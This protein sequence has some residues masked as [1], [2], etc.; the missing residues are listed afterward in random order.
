MHLSRFLPLSLV[1]AVLSCTAAFG[2]ATQYFWDDFD[3][4]DLFDSE[5][6]YS[7]ADEAK[8]GFE[9]QEGSL[10]V[11]SLADDIPGVAVSIEDTP[12]FL[13]KTQAKLLGAQVCDI[14]PYLA[15]FG[16]W[17][18]VVGGAYWGG[19]SSNGRLTLG[20]SFA[21]V[22][23]RKIRFKYSCTEM[24]EQ[25]VHMELRAVGEQFEFTSWL[26]GTTKPT[27]P[28]L[29]MTDDTFD[30]N[31]LVGVYINPSAQLE[32]FALRY[33]AMLPAFAGD[34]N[35]TNALDAEDIDL[36]AEQITIA[37]NNR[38]YDLNEDTIVDEDDLTFL[39]HDLLNTYYGD[40]NLDGEFN[41]SDLVAVFEAGQYEDAI[42]LNSGWA[43]G[44]WNG[45]SEFTSADLVRAFQGGGYEQGPQAAIM[46][47]PEPGTLGCGVLGLIGLLSLAR[48]N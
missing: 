1:A 15:L 2:Q 44:D 36:L 6:A 27:E 7:P 42:A 32:G 29:V 20:E 9:L 5:I 47:V 31:E 4:E 48:R 34:F 43:S 28:D 11:T 14:N 33:F 22:D 40:S 21:P 41:S 3:R 35:G 25:D 17:E 16:R 46:A 19:Y 23:T 24:V 37:S 10:V 8:E 38:V 45:D 12:D 39:I 26:D 18:E 13:L 30:V